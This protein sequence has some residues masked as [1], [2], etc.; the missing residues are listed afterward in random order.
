MSR[1]ADGTAVGAAFASVLVIFIAATAAGYLQGREQ[2]R[3]I[4]VLRIGEVV[5]KIA[6]GV[7][8]VAIGIGG[9]GAIAGFAIGAA[10]VAGAG[11]IAMRHDLQWVHGVLGNS[12]LW[13]STRGLMAIQAGAAVLASMDIVLAGLLVSDRT[14]VGTYQAAQILGRVP[15][16]VGAALSIVLF[17]RLVAAKVDRAHSIRQ[18]LIL[19]E[20]VCI[21]V[22][23]VVGTLPVAVTQRIFP[24]T[25]RGVV[26]LLPWA[27]AA[28]LS[29][30]LVNLV[31]TFFQASGAYRRAA[32]IL[33]QG[34]VLALVLELSGIRIGGVQGLAPMVA[35][36][37]V[38]VAVILVRRARRTWPGCTTR[39][40]RAGVIAVLMAAPLVVLR[41]R[42]V[43]WMAWAVTFA[44]LPALWNLLQVGPGASP[45]P[46][47][48]SIPGSG[49]GIRPRVLHLGFEDPQRPGAGG[50]SVRT[51]EINRVLARDFDITVVCCR[52]PGSRT[53]VDRRR[54]LRPR[55]HPRRRDGGVAGLLR[56]PAD[57]PAPP[58]VGPGR[59]GLRR[60]VLVGRRAVDDLATGD[61]RRAVALR[62]GEGPA[63]PPAVRS[64]RA[65]G[66]V[67]A[68]HP[69]RGVGGA[70]GG[71]APAQPQGTDDRHPQRPRRVGLR[72]P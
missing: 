53:R 17:P 10:L 8:L 9:G 40:A 45:V 35:V 15:V 72:P 46:D 13:L 4:A 6:A 55:R 37:G 64:G 47:A 26:E 63:V 54:A 20:R 39:V 27:A 21:P 18:V 30:G 3:H 32:T 31:T 65:A 57:R 71:A 34:I 66:P 50:G 67:V 23:L 41:E 68:P 33:G 22:A 5:L 38:V 60:A 2:F 49:D 52:Y 51:H 69:R 70:G 19:F 44:A 42:P 59:R 61:R 29:M 12:E 14:S 56:R 36:T 43:L 28:G 62:G 16:Y 25:Y 24:P 58:L 7:G 11:L 48:G 1:Y